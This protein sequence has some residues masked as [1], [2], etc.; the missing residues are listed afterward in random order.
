MALGAILTARYMLV[1]IRVIYFPVI[2]LFF[3]L[4]GGPPAPLKPSVLYQNT[5][6][7]RACAH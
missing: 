1:F 2:V 7:V 3:S 4:R 6:V 5:T